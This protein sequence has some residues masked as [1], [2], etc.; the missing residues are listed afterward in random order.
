M[1]MLGGVAVRMCFR[2]PCRCDPYSVAARNRIRPVLDHGI[3]LQELSSDKRNPTLRT[4]RTMTLARTL[5]VAPLRAAV[6]RRV[7]GVRLASSSKSAS[8]SKTAD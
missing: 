5:F 1:P 7:G 6:A 2:D 4:P 8:R 3:K